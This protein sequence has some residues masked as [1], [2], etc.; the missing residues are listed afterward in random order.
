MPC[1]LTS[2]NQTAKDRVLIPLLSAHLNG[3]L[4]NTVYDFASTVFGT[5]AT[6]EVLKQEKEDT[7]AYGY[8]NGG[9]GQTVVCTSLMRAWHY[10]GVLSEEKNSEELREIV[11]KHFGEEMVADI[12]ANVVSGN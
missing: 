1:A 11:V 5:D 10:H 2:P 9:F 4:G 3:H 12:A 8:E 7:V 6:E